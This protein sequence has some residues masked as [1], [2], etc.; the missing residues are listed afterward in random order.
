MGWV[1]H[2][3]IWSLQQ[4]SCWE[5]H[6]KASSKI[7]GLFQA[8]F[9]WAKPVPEKNCH[10]HPKTF[11]AVPEK[12]RSKHTVRMSLFAVFML[13]FSLKK[14]TTLEP[15]PNLWLLPP[16]LD[17]SQVLVAIRPPEA[18]AAYVAQKNSFLVP[19]LYLCICRD[20]GTNLARDRCTDSKVVG[21]D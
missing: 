10:E 4:F 2:T 1:I 21:N 5:A 19:K 20:K 3:Q 6:S 14:T 18:G 13:C 17:E 8:C 16:K 11:I 9:Q 15:W 12:H 7:E